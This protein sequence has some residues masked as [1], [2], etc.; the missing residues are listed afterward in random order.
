M[1]NNI[2]EGTDKEILNEVIGSMRNY[3]AKMRGQ[4]FIAVDIVGVTFI[5][6][7]WN[8]LETVQK[9]GNKDKMAIL[10]TLLI[11][12][13]ENNFGGIDSLIPNI[14]TFSINELKGSLDHARLR[15]INLEVILMCFFYN[16]TLVLQLLESQNLTDSI[17]SLLLQ[18]IS[19]F[20]ADYEKQRL[21]LGL[22]KL[23]ETNDAILNATVVSSKFAKPIIHFLVE[24]AK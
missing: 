12:L 14:L 17:L 4:F 3:I 19:L 2:A 10:E 13:V 15:L 11:T 5:N 9:G 1:V 23:L 16:S 6:R 7:V 20:K 24:L 18:N 21:M 22:I 8:C